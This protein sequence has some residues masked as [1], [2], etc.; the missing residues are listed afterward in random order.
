MRGGGEESGVDE[1]H[2]VDVAVD[3]GIEDHLGHLPGVLVAGGVAH[4]G[5]LG[6]DAVVAEGEVTGRLLADEDERVVGPVGLHAL[7]VALGGADDRRVVGPGQAP[8]RGDD[9]E[10][11]LVDR[12]GLAQQRVLLAGAGL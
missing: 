3:E 8:V 2:L 11:H 7:E 4:A 6:V 9:D 5:E 10:G 1:A 12:L